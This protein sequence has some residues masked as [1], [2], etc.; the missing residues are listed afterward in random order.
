MQS[1][2]RSGIKGEER[3]GDATEVVLLQDVP[4]SGRVGGRRESCKE[5]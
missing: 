5:T 4:A 2:T 1:L 3:E